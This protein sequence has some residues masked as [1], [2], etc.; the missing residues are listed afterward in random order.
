[1]WDLRNHKYGGRAKRYKEQPRGL[2]RCLDPIGRQPVSFSTELMFENWIL[3]W[4]DL[5]IRSIECAPTQFACL[6]N[7]KLLTIKPHFLIRW[8][9]TSKPSE[10]QVIVQTL[11]RCKQTF[12]DSIQKI[13]AA[14]NVG[15][16]IRT[17]DVIRTNPVLLR[18]LMYLR[19]CT[20]MHVDEPISTLVKE[21]L[22]LLAESKIRDRGNLLYDLK[23]FY[24]YDSQVDAVLFLLRNREIVS[25]NI[26]V[27][28]IGMETQI[29]L[30]R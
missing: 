18:N 20:V 7:G 16:S 29:S 5:A 15:W 19:Q 12:Q 22:S 2:A 1:M 4:G 26:E 27:F 9:D 30:V 17:R 28:P 11:A 23:S 3:L 10:I 25:I 21:I 6:E 13:A 14:N 24:S 8:R